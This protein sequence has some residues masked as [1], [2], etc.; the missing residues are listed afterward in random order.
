MTDATDG[1]EAE[2]EKLDITYCPDCGEMLQPIIQWAS[3]TS[4]D[5]DA[6]CPNHGGVNIE[7]HLI[8]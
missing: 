5:M 2:R 7:V 3:E 6:K 1:R 8:D 4:A